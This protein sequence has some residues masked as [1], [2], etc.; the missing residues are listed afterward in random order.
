MCDCLQQFN[1][2]EKVGLD[3]PF[4]QVVR[5]ARDRTMLESKWALTGPRLTP[6]SNYSQT[7]RI[8]VVIK[9]CPFCGDNLL[10]VI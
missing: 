6:S 4:V 3:S 1:E 8:N 9:Y 2:S 5:F 10:E 7:R